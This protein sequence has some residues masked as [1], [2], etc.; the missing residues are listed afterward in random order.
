MTK[1]KK[2]IKADI[3]PLDVQRS[4]FDFFLRTSG[5]R[6]L[7]KELKKRCEHDEKLQQSS[8]TGD[9]QKNRMW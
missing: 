7:E 3:I 4:M 2:M 6:L 9:V 5:P 8:K 1:I